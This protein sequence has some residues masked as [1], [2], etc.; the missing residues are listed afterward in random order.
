MAIAV[1]SEPIAS[2]PRGEYVP[3]ADQRIVM[4]G[5]TWQA[6]EALLAA[7]GDSGPRVAYLKG[8]LELRS[9]SS[10]HEIITNYFAETVQAHLTRNA[11]RAR[12]CRASISRCSP[13]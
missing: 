6:F 1:K 2:V 5:V 7:R 10:D 12:V 13:R 8:T 4:S 9:P 11:P 3:T